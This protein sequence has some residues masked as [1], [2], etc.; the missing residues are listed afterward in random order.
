MADRS[1]ELV[2][3]CCRVQREAVRYLVAKPVNHQMAPTE[4]ARYIRPTIGLTERQAAANLKYYE[5]M[6]A[7]LSEDHPR[8]KPE[9]IERRAREASARFAERQQ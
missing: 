5:N 7:Q 6:K 1:A 2:T 4:L 8:M 9:A 3:N